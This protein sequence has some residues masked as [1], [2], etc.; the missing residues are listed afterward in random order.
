[1]LD[2]SD[3]QLRRR[4]NGLRAY[5]QTKLANVLFTAELNRRLGATSSV[6]AFA[7]DPGLVKTDIGLK[8][9]PRLVQWIWQQRRAG[10][11]SPEAAAQG[12][13]FL[14]G[15]PSIQ[16][17][18]AV[19]WRHGKPRMPSRQAQDRP[20][21]QRLWALSERMTGMAARE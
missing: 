12:I 7:A 17:T 11:I 3:I 18:H 6:R 4:Y 8:G 10:G 14:L 16:N 13:V 21:A 15:E 19:Y 9:M 20:A 1:V 5:S 2:W